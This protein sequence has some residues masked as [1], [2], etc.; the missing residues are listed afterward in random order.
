MNILACLAMN[1]IKD[2][3]NN[4]SILNYKCFACLHCMLQNYCPILNS[5]FQN[6]ILSKHFNVLETWS[7]EA[8]T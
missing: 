5:M 6:K 1:C 8:V 3:M 2:C 4:P 7:V